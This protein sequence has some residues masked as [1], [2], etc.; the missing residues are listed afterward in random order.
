MTHWLRR[1][2]DRCWLYPSQHIHREVEL[3]YL[4]PALEWPWGQPEW[5]WLCRVCHKV[6]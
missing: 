1:R 2:L 3:I 6:V 4:R 5:G